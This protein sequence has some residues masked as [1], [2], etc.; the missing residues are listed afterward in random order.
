MDDT[1]R[2]QIMGIR[3]K[4]C[5]S[6]LE[7]LASEGELYHGDLADKLKMTPSGLNVIIKK[8][9]ECDPPIIEVMQIGKYKIYTIP[10]AVKEYIENKGS[11][12]KKVDDTDCDE[13]K[14]VL[15]CFQH[16]IEKAGVKWKDLLNLLLQGNEDD[17]DDSVKDCFANLM[18]NIVNASKYNEDELQEAKKFL[19]ND[20]LE[21]LIQSYIDELRECENVLEEISQRENGMKLL[22]HFI[23]R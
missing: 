22:R 13:I 4:Y 1:I 11:N 7:I 15:L 16:F 14:S 17:V 12:K 8:M 3:S 21:Y 6:I 20:V 23:L 18:R 2:K 10:P 9:L 5:E 19:N